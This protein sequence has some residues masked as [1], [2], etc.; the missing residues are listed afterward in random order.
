MDYGDHIQAQANNITWANE[1]VQSPSLFYASLKKATSDTVKMG[2][3]VDFIYVSHV[4]EIN[5]VNA[6]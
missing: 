5:S 4:V 1:E 6:S 2:L 3:A